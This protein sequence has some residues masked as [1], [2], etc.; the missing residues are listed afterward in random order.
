LDQ[1][2]KELGERHSE[3]LAAL[4]DMH[5]VD[6]VNE[7]LLGFLTL[8][9]DVFLEHAIEKKLGHAVD[10]GVSVVPTTGGA[11]RSI[12]VLKL[13][14]SFGWANSWP[15]R[16]TEGASGTLWIPPGIRK[17]K[18]EYPFNAIWGLAREMLDCDVLRIIGCNLSPN[19]WDL[20]SLLFTSRHAHAVSAPYDVE[21]IAGPRTSRHIAKLFPYL[22]V[23][24]ILEITEVGPQIVAENLGRDP[25]EF[26]KLTDDEQGEVTK[27][28]QN[29][30]SNPFHYW[31]RLKGEVMNRD[32]A[33]L[34]TQSNLFSDFVAAGA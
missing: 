1:V 18:S 5:D 27:N 32:L 13:H 14:G 25:I 6:G 21:V 19:D 20:V 4:I 24:S 29:K 3:L 15:I 12:R 31:L 16:T 22:E 28:V 8:N 7:E 10:Y 34:E 11:S 30:I 26:S 17:A 9:Y 2:H 33:S 23:R